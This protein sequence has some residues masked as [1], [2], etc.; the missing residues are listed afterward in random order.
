MTA[1]S[2]SQIVVPTPVG[3]KGGV[4]EIVMESIGLVHPLSS[5]IKTGYV[6]DVVKGPVVTGPAPINPEVQL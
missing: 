2:P 5:I 1:S 4:T 3:T 6:V